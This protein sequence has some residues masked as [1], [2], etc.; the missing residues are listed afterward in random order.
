M[1]KSKSSL[2]LMELILAVLVF[3]IA[4]VICVRLF[5]KSY[6]ISQSTQ[7]L[8]Q[9]VTLCSNAAELYYGFSG[10]LSLLQ[11]ELDQQSMS[12]SFP[13]TVT[14]FYDKDFTLC[15]PGQ[16]SYILRVE[17]SRNEGMLNG[18][19]YILRCGNNEKVYSL[20]CDIYTGTAQPENNIKEAE[21]EPSMAGGVL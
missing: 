3:S 14:F 21:P 16:E 7:E 12:M 19:I 6:I 15:R 8:N 20:N 10:D 2:F 13:G 9:C 18:E 1:K 4:S 11:R 17:T 5:V